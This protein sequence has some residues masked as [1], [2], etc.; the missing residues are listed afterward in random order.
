MSSTQPYSR[1]VLRGSYGAWLRARWRRVVGSSL[2]VAVLAAALTAWVALFVRGPLQWYVLGVVHA[3]LVGAALHIFWMAF[4]AHDARAMHHVR[5]AWG[6]DNTRD[7]LRRARRRRLVWDWVD[8]VELERGDIDHLVVTRRGGILA[9]D[10]KWR[11]ALRTG[12]PSEMARAASD[13]RRRAQG[14]TN[15]HLRRERGAHRGLGRAHEVRPVV[16]LWGAA[17]EELPA[18]RDHDGVTFV[19]GRDLLAW[20][21]TLDGDAIDKDGARS[22]LEHLEAF[23][24][25]REVD[26]QRRAHA[27]RAG[28]G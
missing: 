18:V 21:R 3:A 20:L 28:R 9:V 15:P 2:V 16:V 17:Q 11:T 19:P 13:A 26:A 25:R 4:L 14:L 8:S 23:R 22:L 5:G 24:H 7:E 12:D 6:E 1:R 27:A 10:S